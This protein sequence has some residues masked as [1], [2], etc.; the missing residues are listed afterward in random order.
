MLHYNYRNGRVPRG[1]KQHLNGPAELLSIDAEA[2]HGPLY[3][4]AICRRNV[5][6]PRKGKSEGWIPVVAGVLRS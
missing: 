6:Q 4:G 5:D 3:V 2:A 1:S